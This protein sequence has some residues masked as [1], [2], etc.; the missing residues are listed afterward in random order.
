MTFASFSQKLNR[1]TKTKER[2]VMVLFYSW[3]KTE[4][5]ILY[6]IYKP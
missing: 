5:H 3:T 1:F 6:N 4:L 2:Y